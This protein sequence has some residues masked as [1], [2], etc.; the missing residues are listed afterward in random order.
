MVIEARLRSKMTSMTSPGAK[1]V[2]QAQMKVKTLSHWKVGRISIKVTVMNF[3]KMWP[4]WKKDA[5]H[6]RF[7][8]FDP[9]RAYPSWT[10]RHNNQRNYRDKLQ[11]LVLAQ[12]RRPIILIWVL[13]QV[14]TMDRNQARGTTIIMCAISSKI[15]DRAHVATDVNLGVFNNISTMLPTQTAWMWQTIKCTLFLG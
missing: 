11:G 4:A 14:I 8:H 10:G 2:H 9:E 1:I 5:N 12:D 6:S 15:L 7:L 13:G 3:R